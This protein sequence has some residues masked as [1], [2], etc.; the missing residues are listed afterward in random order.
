MLTPGGR[1]WL[2][3]AP[4]L[5]MCKTFHIIYTFNLLTAKLRIE[6]NMAHSST[7]NIFILGFNIWGIA[8]FTLKND[9][10]PLFIKKHVK[11][12]IVCFITLNPAPLF[13]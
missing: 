1:F 12:V 11:N 7:K 9:N 8:V 4:V 2:R 10:F 6:K 13:F 3:D 5:I